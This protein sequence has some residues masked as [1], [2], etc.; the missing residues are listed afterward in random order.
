[1]SADPTSRDAHTLGPRADW[2]RQSAPSPTEGVGIDRHI[3]G[4]AIRIPEPFGPLLQ[5]KRAAFNDPLADSIP[6]H[7]TL[8]GPTPVHPVARPALVRHLDEVA[9]HVAPF[10]MALRGT[11]TFRPVSDVV[12]VQ[13]ARGISGCE[14]LEQRIRNG[15]YAAPL[16]FP[17]HPHVTV[18]HDV[19]ESD[20]DRAFE[21]LSGFRADFDVAEFWLFEQ[22]DLGDWHPVRSFPLTGDGSSP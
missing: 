9:T 6:A 3:I 12:F 17:Y 5:A 16:T 2:G 4:V 20:L 7:V 19:S 22:G 11:G 15:A 8:L 21:D 14:R 13:V 10:P 1:M 18:A